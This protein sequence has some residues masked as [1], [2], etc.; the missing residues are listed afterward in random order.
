MSTGGSWMT[1]SVE[2]GR[3]VTTSTR[4]KEGVMRYIIVVLF[5]FGVTLATADLSRE[6]ANLEMQSCNCADAAMVGH[7]EC[8][9]VVGMD[10]LMEEGMWFR[11]RQAYNKDC[12]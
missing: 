11:Y 1:T 6:N 9:F 7:V 10:L 2:P 5:G 3:E 4:M 8:F 12:P